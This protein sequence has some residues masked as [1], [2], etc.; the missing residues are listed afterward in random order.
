MGDGDMKTL[1]WK[2]SKFNQA[3][4]EY[5]VATGKDMADVLN[6]AL[7]NVGF[8]TARATPKES[9]ADIEAELTKKG[10]GKKDRLALKIA[11]KQLRGRVGKTYTTRKGK[12]RTFRRVTRK[13]IGAK[14]KRL[15]TKRQKRRGFLRAAWIAA[16]V[17]AGIRGVKKGGDIIRDGKSKIGSGKQATPKHLH[18]YLGNRAYGRLA[19]KNKS[20]TAAKMEAALATGIRET[21]EDML[22]YAQKVMAKTAAKHSARKTR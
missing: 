9:A 8:K 15:I 13:Q 7:R 3:L 10:T 4:A 5:A 2:S 14:A 22:Q 18:A 20:A 1:T 6:R 17:A 21:R 11:T 12:T 19:G 16:M